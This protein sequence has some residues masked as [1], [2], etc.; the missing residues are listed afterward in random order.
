MNRFWDKVDKSSYC[1][2]W[3]A[4]KNS[5][6][7][8][9]FKLDG[10]VNTPN[11]AHRVAWTLVNGEIPKGSCCLHKCDNPEC[12]NP[13]HLFL[14]TQSDNMKDMV[15]KGRQNKAKGSSASNSTLIEDDVVKIKK[16]LL[17]GKLDHASIASMFG[18]SISN[19]STI[20][21]GRTWRHV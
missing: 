3:I 16:L 12:V 18:V 1:W 17:Y 11:L 14:G 4:A 21:T 6:G 13:D 7:Y 8:G 5:K 9:L 15:A 2:K 20:N 19:I 10:R